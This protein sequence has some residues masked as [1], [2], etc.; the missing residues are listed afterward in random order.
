M[1]YTERVAAWQQRGERQEFRGRSIHTFAYS[2]AGPL[3]V[4]LHGFPSSSYDFRLLIER[5]A[6]RALLTFDFLG[7][8]LSDK[9]RDHVYSLAWQ[10]D[11]VEELVVRA[12]PI[13]VRLLAGAPTVERRGR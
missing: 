3:A 7:F 10:A 13:R 9:P 4:F 12:Q 2:G 11:L 5:L 1:T 8:G 6:G